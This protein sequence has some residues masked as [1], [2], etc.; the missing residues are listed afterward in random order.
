VGSWI[1]S[2]L[3]YANV[4][5]TLALFVALGGGAVAAVSLSKN[6][7]K[8]RHIANGQVKRS[9]IGKNAV[10]SAKVKARSL[11]ASD[12]KAGQLPE[13]PKGDPGEPGVA[14]VA[15][16][17]QGTGTIFR[18]SLAGGSVRH[19]ATG[20]YCI[21]LPFVPVAASVARSTDVLNQQNRDSLVV[22]AVGPEVTCVAGEDL[23]V[24][25]LEVDSDDNGTIDNTFV[26][27]GFSLIAN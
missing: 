27:R 3:T 11:L 6:S 26:D 12:F 21:D 14:R 23:L 9:D 7:V 17:I 2:R 1:R 13:G 20:Q 8:S 25:T 18:G 16:T 5:A 4:V 22:V 19:A 15:A 24:T 10:T